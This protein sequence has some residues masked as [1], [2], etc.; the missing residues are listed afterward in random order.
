MD[1]GSLDYGSI[2]FC[3]LALG[4]YFPMW[5]LWRSREHLLFRL[6]FYK[7]VWRVHRESLIVW[8][9][10]VTQVVSLQVIDL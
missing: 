3:M 6:S 9:W 4:K 10:S 7:R 1:P 2:G 5:L 8:V